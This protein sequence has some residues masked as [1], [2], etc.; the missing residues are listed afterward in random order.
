MAKKLKAKPAKTKKKA[1]VKRPS[2]KKDFA[3]SA[4]AVFQR[5]IG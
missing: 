3:Q 4:F 2:P 5:T 1:A